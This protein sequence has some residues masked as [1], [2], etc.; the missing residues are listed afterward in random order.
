MMG[1]VSGDDVSERPHGNRIVA[2]HAAAKPC[3]FRQVA[4]K[5]NCRLTNCSELLKMVRP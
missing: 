2:R 3:V 5:R 1:N 4:E